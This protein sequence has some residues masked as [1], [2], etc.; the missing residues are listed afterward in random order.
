[1]LYK[2]PMTNFKAKQSIV[3][4]ASRHMWAQGIRSTDINI[5]S[6]WNSSSVHSL[7]SKKLRAVIL[8]RSQFEF[9]SPILDSGILERIPR[10]LVLIFL[11]YQKF[12]VGVGKMAQCIKTLSSKS[13]WVQSLEPKCHMEWTDSY[14]LSLDV[15]VC[16]WI[17]LKIKKEHNVDVDCSYLC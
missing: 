15:C 17:F 1:M 2:V 4:S 8:Q 3:H 7:I 16:V 10:Y 9:V 12:S 6:V 11:E 13:I 5:S 14:R